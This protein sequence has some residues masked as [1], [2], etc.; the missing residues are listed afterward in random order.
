MTW[1]LK[2]NTASNDGRENNMSQKPRNTNFFFENIEVNLGQTVK[3]YKT[4]F[5]KHKN[6]RRRMFRDYEKARHEI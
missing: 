4:K 1:V 5:E 6:L 2:S 3:S